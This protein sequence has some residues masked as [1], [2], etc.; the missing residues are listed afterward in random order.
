MDDITTLEGCTLPVAERPLRLAEFD[1]LFSR[2]V[3]RVDR[4]DDEVR[5]HLSGP[6]GLA[7]EVRYLTARESTCCSFFAF[8]LED[9]DEDLL[10]RISVPPERRE[11]L[12]ALA[13][14]AVELS[15]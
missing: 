2:W 14:R 15:R 7:A 11:I 12:T 8:T 4:D 13:D 9:G 10:L 6:A 1:D 5:L 3:R